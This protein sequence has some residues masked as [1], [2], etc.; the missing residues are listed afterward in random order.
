MKFMKYPPLRADSGGASRAKVAPPQA[1]RN[2]GRSFAP[3]HEVSG[4]AILPAS[5]LKMPTRISTI[6]KQKEPICFRRYQTSRGA[7]ASLVF[8][9]PMVI[10]S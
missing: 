1:N 7:C 6:S 3:V 10:K 5:A 4:L 2:F 9:L 8:G